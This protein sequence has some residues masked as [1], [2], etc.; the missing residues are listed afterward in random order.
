[1]KNRKLITLVILVIVAVAA[2]VVY[3]TRQPHTQQQH[4]TVSLNSWIGWAPLYLAQEKGIFQKDGAAVDL[5]RIE[6]TGARKNTM[7]SGKV[8]G[9]ATSLD[10]F[11]L[12]SAQ[13]VP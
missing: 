5:V 13:G 10:N 7:I 4:L 1:M 11:Q 12:D 9:Y 6:D 2:I 8:D 3:K